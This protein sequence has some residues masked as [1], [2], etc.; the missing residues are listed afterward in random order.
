MDY[1]STVAFEA[2]GIIASYS[3]AY[4]WIEDAASKLSA[5]YPELT[6]ADGDLL[7]ITPSNA[8]RHATWMALQTFHFGEDAARKIG[9]AHEYHLDDQA[10]S[11]VDQHNNEIG[12]EIGKSARSEEEIYTRVHEAMSGYE[13]DNARL[14]ASPNDVR[15]PPELL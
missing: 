2:I 6:D 7:S 3:V 1:Q 9:D 8:A 12:R 14:I 11:W 4:G 13:Q 5:Q 10:D 15:I